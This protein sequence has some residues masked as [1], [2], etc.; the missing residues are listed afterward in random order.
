MRAIA[1]QVNRL[2][3]WKLDRVDWH[4]HGKC[5]SWW[6]LRAHSYY[7]GNQRVVNWGRFALVFERRDWTANV[8]RTRSER[9]T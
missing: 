7:S 5:W 2:V 4:R 3:S 9:Q 8:E 1:S 6:R